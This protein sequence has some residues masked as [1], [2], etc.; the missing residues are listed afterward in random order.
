MRKLLLIAALGLTGWFWQQGKLPF[1]SPAGA[2]DEAGNPEVWLFTIDNCGKACDMGRDHLKNRRVTFKE[3][4][5]DPNDKNN[6]NVQLWKD[7]GGGGFPLIVAGNERIPNSGTR[8]SVATLLALNY[9]DRY[10]TR[11]EKYLFKDHFYPDG[12]PKIVMYGADWCGYC[13]KLR[14]EFRESNVDFTE[15]DVDRHPSKEKIMRTMEI[16]GYPATWVGY[17]R[18]NGSNLRA[19]NKVL[20]S[21]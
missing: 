1:I 3:F 19:V 13:R 5:I 10:L 2:F 20:K 16:G 17:T 12:S 9:G 8:S 7:V 15:I 14:N 18:V 4:R 21:Y 11:N 6:P